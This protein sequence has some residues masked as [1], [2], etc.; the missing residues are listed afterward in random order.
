MK[1]APAKPAAASR[2]DIASHG[3]SYCVIDRD[4]REVSGLLD[5]RTAATERDT[6]NTAAASG[7]RALA[8]ALGALDEY[9]LDGE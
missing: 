1:S 7:R 6:L 2:F 3:E 5:Y 8:R 9:D 4:G